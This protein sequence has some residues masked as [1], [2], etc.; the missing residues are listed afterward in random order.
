MSI[1]RMKKY[2]KVLSNPW[3]FLDL[4]N[5]DFVSCSMST[6]MDCEWGFLAQ[7]CSFVRLLYILYHETCD[8][9]KTFP[10]GSVCERVE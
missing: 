8:K 2:Y 9:R 5:E 3:N 1:K 6:Y 7:R 10:L 4:Q